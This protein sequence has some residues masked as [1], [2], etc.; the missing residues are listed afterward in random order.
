[1]KNGLAVGEPFRPTRPPLCAEAQ[2]LVAALGMGARCRLPDRFNYADPTPGCRPLAGREGVVTENLLQRRCRLAQF[3]AIAPLPVALAA[4][5]KLFIIFMTYFAAIHHR[6]K[7][8]VGG[9]F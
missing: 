8:M 5:G 9:R 6:Y 2:P 7:W 1:M 4:G 3:P